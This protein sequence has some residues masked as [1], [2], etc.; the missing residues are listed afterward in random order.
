[1]T[2]STAQYTTRKIIIGIAGPEFVGKSTVAQIIVTRTPT[3]SDF[4]AVAYI[5][6]MAA[7]IY[8]A[9]SGIFGVEVYFIKAHK[10][11]IFTEATAP[12]PCLVGKSW[13]MLL[14]NIGSGWGRT[15]HP[16]LWA[17][18]AVRREK[19]WAGKTNLIVFD[20][21]RFEQEAKQCDLL[22]EL[23]RDGI[24]YAKTHDS[25]MGLPG[26]IPRTKLQ[27]EEGGQ[28]AAAMHIINA[29]LQYTAV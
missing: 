8:N 29:A 24:T 15:L 25:N 21:V 1:M 2:A 4:K 20:D 22:F 14:Q 5:G 7:P 10:D 23:S 3:I 27:V 9:L 11:E 28:H 26:Y 13:R 17:Q 16:E 19:T 12:V 18:M 6:S